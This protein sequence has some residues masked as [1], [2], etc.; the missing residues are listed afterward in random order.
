MQ[1][2]DTDTIWHVYNFGLSLYRGIITDKAVRFY[3]VNWG[4]ML[5]LILHILYIQYKAYDIT[6][7]RITK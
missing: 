6:T 7:I 4:Y 3:A 2:L 1:Y 5:W